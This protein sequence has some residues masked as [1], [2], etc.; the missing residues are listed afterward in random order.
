MFKRIGKTSRRLI[1]TIRNPDFGLQYRVFTIGL[2]LFLLFYFSLSLGAFGSDTRVVDGDTIKIGDETIRIENLDTPEKGSRAECLAEQMLADLATKRL[3]EIL[4][5]VQLVIVRSG[6][7]RYDR[8]LATLFA[9]GKDVG[10]TLVE[11]GFSRPW[12]GRQVDWCT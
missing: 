5:G 6:T 3:Q 4:T 10:A 1:D 9:D 7:D 12:E 8:T 2:V 11:E